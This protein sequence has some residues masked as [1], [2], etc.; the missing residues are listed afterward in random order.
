MCGVE[1]PLVTESDCARFDNGN[2]C[3][4]PS[5]GEIRHASVDKWFT[6]AKGDEP[7]VKILTSE[8]LIVFDV[9]PATV[10][11]KLIRASTGAK[12]DIPALQSN[13]TP[14]PS[15]KDE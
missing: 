14:N 11:A 12:R 4:H 7:S 13:T 8:I 2:A 15:Q 9:K 3:N 10:P 5:I 6:P 1:P